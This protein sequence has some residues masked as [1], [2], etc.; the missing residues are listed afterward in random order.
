MIIIISATIYP[1]YVIPPSKTI[2][3]FMK[4]KIKIIDLLHPTFKY[5][6]N[7][8]LALEDH[9]KQQPIFSGGSNYK[10]YLEDCIQQVNKLVYVYSSD[11]HVLVQVKCL[12]KIKVEIACPPSQNR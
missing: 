1:I 6:G 8:S 10:Q 5:D 2:K 12:G 9:F 7:N 3:D 4:R 11:F